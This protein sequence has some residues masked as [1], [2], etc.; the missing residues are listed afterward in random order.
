MKLRRWLVIAYHNLMVR[1]WQR[2]IDVG[3][4]ERDW[5]FVAYATTK[6]DQHILE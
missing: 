4:F 2:G 1:Y 5:D 3:R 6:R